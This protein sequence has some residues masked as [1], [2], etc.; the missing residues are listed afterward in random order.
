METDDAHEAVV[1]LV[2]RSGVYCASDDLSVKKVSTSTGHTLYVVIAMNGI[3][4]AV[5]DALAPLIAPRLPHVDGVWVLRPNE[6]SK[7]ARQSDQPLL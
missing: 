5:K 1:H 7:L 6:V 3:A 4:H 2:A